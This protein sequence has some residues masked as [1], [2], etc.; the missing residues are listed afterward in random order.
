VKVRLS[1]EDRL[2]SLY[3][4]NKAN[5]IC[6]HCKKIKG[7]KK[8]QASHYFGRRN[9]ALRW[10]EKNVSAL[11][12]T[13]HMVI[14]TENPHYHTKWMEKKLGKVGF[15]QLANA[16]TKLKKWTKDELKELRIS[17]RE[18]LKEYN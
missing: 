12:F 3:I 5:G 10:D 11:C 14:M 9:K 8:L 1:E 13:C 15:R 18:K 2:F 17:L 7:V 4:R 16:S 6:E